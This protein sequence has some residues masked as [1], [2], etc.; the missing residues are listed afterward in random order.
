MKSSG[1]PNAH[2]SMIRTGRAIRILSLDVE[3]LKTSGRPRN[4]G[5]TVYDRLSM[6]AGPKG[7]D[8]Q[9]HA[10]GESVPEGVWEN[11]APGCD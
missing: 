8:H 5:F 4:S 1:A 10:V 11:A 6:P 7:E 3:R 2:C 9:I